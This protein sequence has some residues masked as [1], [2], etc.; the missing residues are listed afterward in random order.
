MG[1]A[2]VG[3][4][5]RARRVEIRDAAARVDEAGQSETLL[6]WREREMP[7]WMNCLVSVSGDVERDARVRRGY[8]ACGQDYWMREEVKVAVSRA[9]D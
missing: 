8:G 9:I 1:R 4:D 5:R 3:L 6:D 2:V 7:R